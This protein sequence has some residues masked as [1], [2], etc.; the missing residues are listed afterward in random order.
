MSVL[1]SNVIKLE[2]VSANWE[3]INYTRVHSIMVPGV[4]DWITVDQKPIGQKLQ[5]TEYTDGMG[6]NIE[7]VSRQMATPDASQPGAWGDIV[8]FSVYDAYGRTPQQYL[9]YTKVDALAPGKFKA[10]P[11]GDQQQ[12][13]STVYNETSPFQTTTY[14]SSPLDRSENVRSSGA[15]WNASPGVTAFYG[16]NDPSDNVQIFNIGFNTGDIPVSAGAYPANVLEKSTKTDEKGRQ[17]IEYRDNSGNVILTKTQIDASPSPAHSGWSC[18]YNVYDDFGLLRYKLQPEA[19][20]WLDANGWSFSGSAGGGDGQQV[21]NEWCFRYEYDEKGRVILKKAPGAK[22]LYMVYDAR[23]RM[24][25]AQDAIQRA[26]SPGEWN[27]TFYDD[28]DR[29]VLAALYETAKSAADLQTDLNNSVTTTTLPQTVPN[30][31]YSPDLHYFSRGDYSITDY[32]ASNSITL[33]SGFMSLPNDNFVVEIAPGIPTAATEIL[34]TFNNPIPASVQSDPSAF[35]PLRYNYY[36]DYTYPNAKPFDNGFNNSLAY[37][38]SDP[39][40]MPIATDAR[41]I[42]MQTGSKV[43]VLGTSTFL[44]SSFYYDEKGRSIQVLEDNLKSAA[45]IVTKQYHFDGRLLSVDERHTAAGTAYSNFDILSKNIFDLIGRPIS[46]QAKVGTNA[47]KTISTYDLDDI[48]RVKTKH[49]DPGYTGGSGAELESLT[50]SYNIHNQITGINKDYALKTPG[51]YDKWGHYFGLYLGYDN[52]DGIFAAQQ[53][54]GSITGALWS[55]QGDDVQRKYDFSYDN[56]G[57]L[58]KAVFVEKQSPGDAWSNAKMDFSVTGNGDGNTIQYDNNGNL[59]SMVQRG[60]VPGNQTPV[61]IDDLHYTYVRLSNR[62]LSVK[63]FGTA[64]AADGKLGDFSDGTAGT[65]DDYLFDDNGNLIVDRNKGITSVDGQTNK[66]ILYNFLDKPEKVYINGKGTVQ[67]VYD[68]DGNKL[69]K[70][71]TPDGGGAPVVTTYIGRYVYVANDLQYINFE[72]GRIRAVKYNPL[73]NGYDKLI[74]DGNIDL[75]GAMRGAFD[76]FIEDYQ[77]NVRMILTEESHLGSNSCTM[78]SER[79]LNEEALFGKVDASGNP[80]PDNEVKARF[81][82]IQ[83]PG[84]SIGGGWQNASIGNYVSRLGNLVGQKMGPNTLLKVMAGDQITATSMYYYQDPVVNVV[85]GPSLITDLISSLASAIGGSPITSNLMHASAGNIVSPLNGY[86]PFTSKADPDATNASGSAP[87]A[88]LAVLF[89]DERFNFIGEG[90][91]TDRVSQAGNGA[92]LLMV[93]SARA[94]KNGYAF[95]YVANESDETVYFDNLKVANVHSPILEEDHYYAYGLKIAGISSK[96]LADPNEGFTTNKNLYNDKELIDEADLNW[97]DYGFRNYDPQIARFVQLDPL[98]DSYPELTPYQYASN[99]PILNIDVDGLEGSGSELGKV[100]ISNMTAAE[101]IKPYVDG[102]IVRPTSAQLYRL[103]F[104]VIQRTQVTAR[105]ALITA[106]GAADADVHAKTIG[107]WNVDH[108]EE[109]TN[110]A[111]KMFYIYGRINADVINVINGTNEIRAGA[112]IVRAGAALAPESGGAGLVVSGAG[113]LTMLHGTGRALVATVDFAKSVTELYKVYRVYSVS[114]SPKHDPSRDKP[115]G[116]P[117]RN[118]WK[119][120]EE[121]SSEIRRSNRFGKFYKSKSDNLWW[122]EDNAGHGGSKFKVFEE[123]SDGLH[124]KADADKFGDF[125]LGKHKGPTGL[126]VS[127]KDLIKIK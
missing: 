111:D 83:I 99:D 24:V 4:S 54:D 123:G 59:I 26:K 74:I 77:G 64:G 115:D 16:L 29:P 97:Y 21:L 124:W 40:V 32:I 105:L 13:Y 126:F 96:K 8:K 58:N 85:N 3:D 71:Y 67:I 63:D 20:K 37:Q 78:E 30:P 119:L 47:F 113:A 69:Q 84:N 114:S 7:S 9:P 18:V 120:T 60:I 14:E 22:E 52:K 108:T 5:T 103:L 100:M 112:G 17:V 116:D 35:V 12:Y 36:D 88:Y 127:W 76:Y 90:S 42:N 25:F 53:L 65:G 109:Y 57:R 92:P 98:T 82:A 27:T 61:N 23:D 43:R 28:L 33:E 51:Q 93:P 55:T 121:N 2:L 73:D 6:R 107:I 46:I 62:L 44:T 41:T 31:A 68:A 72:E 80:T 86:I 34:M 39:T 110:P 101:L 48:G 106:T 122:S 45:D 66:G 10:S 104:K 11:V 56:N 1:Y 75:P 70:T 49:L 38:N 50:Y 79:S 125:I 117:P 91:K 89:F 94:P 15:S 102:V 87:K 95:V 81:P 19:V 118:E